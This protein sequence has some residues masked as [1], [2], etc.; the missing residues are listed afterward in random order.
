MKYSWKEHK[1]R[2]R[3]MNRMYKSGQAQLLYVKG[4]NHN[5]PTII[6][7]AGTWTDLYTM[8][9]TTKKIVQ[10]SFV[11]N[12]DKHWTSLAVVPVSPNVTETVIIVNIYHAQYQKMDLTENGWDHKSILYC[13]V[14]VTVSTGSFPMNNKGHFLWGKP[15]L[16]VTLLSLTI[17]SWLT[18]LGLLVWLG[19]SLLNFTKAMLFHLMESVMCT[20]LSTYNHQDVHFCF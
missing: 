20:Y 11:Q 18:A 1:D 10:N 16:T 8:S 19:Y 17:T 15:A 9:R 5:I 6:T 4:I 14:Q 12:V 2:N 13:W 3:H 7:K